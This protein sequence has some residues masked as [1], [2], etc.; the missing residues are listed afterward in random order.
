[1]AGH[2]P[3][4]LTEDKRTTDQVNKILDRIGLSSIKNLIYFQKVKCCGVTIERLSPEYAM[5]DNTGEI[6]CIIN[7][8]FKKGEKDELP[9]V[10]IEVHLTPQGKIKQLYLVA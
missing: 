8:D 9:G 5:E 4:S 10:I 1:M 7:W 2:L 6:F 3:I